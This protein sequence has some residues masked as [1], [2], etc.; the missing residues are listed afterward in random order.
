MSMVKAVGF[1]LDGTLFDHR[2]SAESGVDRF[3]KELGLD[4]SYQARDIWFAAEEAQFERW[5]SGEISFQEQRR[6]RLRAVLPVLGITPPTTATRLDELFEVY[7]EAYRDEWRA[8]P[9]SLELLTALRAAGYRTGLLTNGTEAQQLDKLR[10]TGLDRAFDFIGISEAI[11]AQKPDARAF[12]ALAQGLRFDPAEC[13]FVGDHPIHDVAGARA[14]GMSGLLVD[15]SADPPGS[16]AEAVNAYLRG[17]S[18]L[19]SEG[20]RG[21]GT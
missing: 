14:T 10:C 17:G 5:R 7:V 21:Q 12:H 16:I 2:G 18:T 11:G 13:L 3:F 20:F 19:A 8:F 6:E 4:E 9:D 1:D 15:R